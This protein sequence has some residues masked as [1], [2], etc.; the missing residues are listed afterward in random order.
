MSNTVIDSIAA[1]FELLSALPLL[2][3]ESPVS[4]IVT[5]MRRSALSWK[6][7]ATGIVAG[8]LATA[9]SSQKAIDRDHYRD[10]TKQLSERAGQKDWQGA[11]N[12]LTQIGQELPVATPRYLLTVAS[13]EAHLGHK[14][15][16][17]KWLQ[18]FAATGLYYEPANDNDLKPL[19]GERAGKKLAVQMREN[20]KSIAHAK[21]VCSLPQADT[22]P[23]DI[24]YVP[25]LHSFVVSSIRHHTLFRISLP[26][27][28]AKE[29][30]MQELPLGKDAKR[31]PTMAVSFDARRNVLWVTAS[32]MPGFKGFPKE[33]EGKAVLMEVDPA[34][35]KLLHSFA[36]DT[37]G[38]AVLG[39][40]FV[41]AEGTVYVTDSIGGGVYRLRGDV[42]TARLEQIADGLFS[43]Q[44]PVVA[45]DSKRL[46]VADYAMGVAVLDLPPPGSQAK[47]LYLAHPENIATVGLD[48]LYLDGDSLIGIQNGTEPIRI[49]RLKLNREQTQIIS[50]DVL[51]QASD[52]MGDPTH[53][54]LANGWF[55]VSA[56]VGWSKVDDDTGELKQGASFTPPVLLRFRAQPA[57]MH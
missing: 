16:A 20:S 29:C 1:R 15:E 44:T 35:G 54:T 5:M 33:D 30:S 57:K 41:A 26:S 18:R 11:R 23:E 31:W 9:G 37:K 46:F 17:L 40:M 13:V 7:I 51:E 56:N 8:C 49:L 28:D 21:I 55:Y 34:S 36:P 47:P 39:D 2:T 43:P 10:L 3:N 6:F 45:G 14:E 52:Q 24:A 25:S 38:P 50:S 53:A 19:M 27:G 22:M 32:A 48:G 4:Q 12:V 42:E